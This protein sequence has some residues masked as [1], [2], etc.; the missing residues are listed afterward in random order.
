M[1]RANEKIYYNNYP[2]VFIHG[3][4]G[5][6]EDD[7]LDEHLL[8]YWGR[9]N[10]NLLAHHLFELYAELLYFSA[11][12]ADNDTWLSAVDVDSDLIVETLDLNSGN[13]SSI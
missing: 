10:K 9:G 6:G 13:T 12:S 11:L 5:W 1:E 8:P 4:T 3:M 2:I 7:K